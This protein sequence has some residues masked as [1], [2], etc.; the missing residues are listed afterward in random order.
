VLRT[1]KAVRFVIF[2]NPVGSVIFTST[3]KL[4]KFSGSHVLSFGDRHVA[5]PVPFSVTL[6]ANGE[7]REAHVILQ[8]K[9]VFS[10]AADV[11]SGSH[12]QQVVAHH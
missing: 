6:R 5:E 4:L 10:R 11:S 12:R 9:R 2:V 7:S 3:A 1:P 8:L